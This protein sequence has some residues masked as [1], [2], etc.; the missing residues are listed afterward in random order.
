MGGKGKYYQNENAP[1][2]NYLVMMLPISITA[3]IFKQARIK[4]SK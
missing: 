4:L 1:Q 3:D 2:F